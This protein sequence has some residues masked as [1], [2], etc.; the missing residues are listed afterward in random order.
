[1][2]ERP[3]RERLTD[4]FWTPHYNPKSD[5]SRTL[6][7]PLLV[8]ALYR[9]DWRVVV[10]AVLAAVVNPVAFP[11]PDEEVD[12]WM[13]R[14]VCAERWWLAEGRHCR[15]RLAGRAQRAE[16]PGVRVRAV[17][18]LRTQARSSR[19]RAR[20][21]DRVETRLD[22]V[23]RATIRRGRTVSDHRTWGSGWRLPPHSAG[24]CW[25]VPSR[26]CQSSASNP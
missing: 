12:G 19:D 17:R 16:R 6:V 25:A 24:R 23:H 11:P 7:G 21:L 3:R 1:M 10:V 18:R 26:T 2:D 20:P 22:R 13:T 14:A 15:S 5:W 9:R 4:V 8:L